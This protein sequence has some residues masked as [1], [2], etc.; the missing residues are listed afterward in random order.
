M[1]PTAAIFCLWV[2]VT[3]QARVVGQV[4]SE[5]TVDKASYGAGE[6][7]Q[8][9]MRLTNAGNEVVVLKSDCNGPAFSVD[10]VELFYQACVAYTHAFWFAPGSWLEFGWTMAPNELGL[11]E[12]DG[13]HRLVARFAHLADTLH[14]QAAASEGFVVDISFDTGIHPDTL[15]SIKGRLNATVLDHQ[16]FGNGSTHE[17]WQ[18]RGQTVTESLPIYTAHPSLRY[19]EPARFLGNIT[20][21]GTEPEELPVEITVSA[22]Y[23]N[24]FS[25]R[26]S[27]SVTVASPQVVLVDMYDV[28]GRSVGRLYRGLMLPGTEYPMSFHADGHVAGLYTY[29]VTGE[30]F[31]ATGHVTLVR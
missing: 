11:P 21:V 15:S 28:L 30:F 12:N 3:S 23:P 17:R 5:S 31:R 29:R 13:T 1:K 25:N 6:V 8:V 4:V 20:Q 9:T 27:F 16:D 26:T 24:P 19:F 22:A 7:I 10:E 2:L 14:F 18:T